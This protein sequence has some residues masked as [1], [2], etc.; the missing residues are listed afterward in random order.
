MQKG[1]ELA[2]EA[3]EEDRKENWAAA[4]D[5]YKRALEYFGTH[6]KYDKNP[7]SR[8]MISNKVRAGGDGWGVW[9]RWGLVGAVGKGSISCMDCMLWL[10][11]GCSTQSGIL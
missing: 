4:L 11:G 6:L 8:E 10:S 1:I 5:L 7:K 3:V 2:K 9:C